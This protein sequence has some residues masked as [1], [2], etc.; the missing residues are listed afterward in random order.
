[1]LGNF[2]ETEMGESRYNLTL[3]NQSFCMEYL[4]VFMKAE[5]LNL[6]GEHIIGNTNCNKLKQ[7][8]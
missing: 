8:R 7:E 1:M 4:L 3:K 6:D 5:G 2:M